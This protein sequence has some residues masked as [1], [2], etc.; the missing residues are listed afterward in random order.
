MG[1]VLTSWWDC[2]Q[3]L[4]CTA[5]ATGLP[6]GLPGQRGPAVAKYLCMELAMLVQG[7]PWY[8]ATTTC[9]LRV[10]HTKAYPL[11]LPLQ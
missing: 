8:K 9:L 1:V 6:D 7:N 5:G 2:Y 4:P 10:L 3:C 11:A